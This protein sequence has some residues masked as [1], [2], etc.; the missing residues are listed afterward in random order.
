[1][2]PDWPQPLEPG[3]IVDIIA[4]S[5]GFQPDIIGAIHSIIDSWGLKAR[6]PNNI[7]GEDLLCAN[8]DEIR[9][10][11]LKDALYNDDSPYIWALRGGYGVTRLLPMLNELPTPKKQKLLIGFSDITALHIFLNQKWGWPS[12]HGCGARQIAQQKVSAESGDLLK[13]ILFSNQQD[14]CI[15]PLKPLN[16]TANNTLSLQAHIV[17]GNLCL[18]QSSLGTFWQLD[19]KDKIILLE[20]VD[21]KGYRIDRSLIHLAQAG[22]FDNAKAVL[23]ADF[24]GG[25]ENDGASLV[26]PVI[27][28]F[29]T[30]LPIPAFRIEGIGHGFVNLPIP[31]GFPVTLKTG[32]D[33]KLSFRF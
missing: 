30:S 32:S 26:E 11:H 27:N 14:S 1:M 23:F 22:I 18:V 33:A 3:D 20:E 17:G 8:S 25:K 6:I 24:I 5:F 13:S 31:L 21:E 9:F 29:A 19:G 12:L 2:H 28:R 7:F 10:Q 4:P 16:A 15:Y